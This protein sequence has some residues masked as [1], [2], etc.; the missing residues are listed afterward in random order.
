[1]WLELHELKTIVLLVT[2][3][4]CTIAAYPSVKRQFSAPTHQLKV[5]DTVVIPNHSGSPA[6]VLNLLVGCPHCEKMMPFFQRLPTANKI[7]NGSVKLLA[8]FHP[9]SQT[10]YGDAVQKWVTNKRVPGLVMLHDFPIHQSPVLALLD[11]KGK[12][13]KL[14]IG[15]FPE[16]DQQELLHLLR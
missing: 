7:A 14:L 9:D 12:V 16:K 8:V 4:F 10:G 13:Q 5:G 6:L 2:C 15:E 3:A 1:M 11:A